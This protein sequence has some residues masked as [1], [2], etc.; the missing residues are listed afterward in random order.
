MSCVYVLVLVLLGGFSPLGVQSFPGG[1]PNAACS[2]LAPDPVAHISG[3]ATTPV[4]YSLDLSSF[5]LPDS[6]GYAYVPGK[7]YTY[8]QNWERVLT[9]CHWL[10]ASIIYS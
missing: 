8:E 10:D 3:P 4:P 2:T 6:S 9:I 1:A 7:Q 5:L